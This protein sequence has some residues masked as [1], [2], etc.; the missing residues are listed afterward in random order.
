MKDKKKGGQRREKNI[1]SLIGE[2]LEASHFKR[3]FFKIVCKA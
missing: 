1:T 2:Q 3:I